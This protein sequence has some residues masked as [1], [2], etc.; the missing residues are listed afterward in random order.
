MTSEKKRILTAL[1]VTLAFALNVWQVSSPPVGLP[2]RVQ[3]SD[4]HF[5]LHN[6]A[7]YAP[8]TRAGNWA[9]YRELLALIIY[10][11]VRLLVSTVFAYSLVPSVPFS[12]FSYMYNGGYNTLKLTMPGRNVGD[13]FPEYAW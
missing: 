5:A 6:V 12:Y 4:H 3:A 7:T 10:D 1:R 9:S 11:K 8:P 2:Q 13:A